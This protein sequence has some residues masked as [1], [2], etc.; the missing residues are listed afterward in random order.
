MRYK[1]QSHEKR[2]L[3]NNTKNKIGDS[4][5]LSDVHSFTCRR[6][7]TRDV[8]VTNETTSLISNRGAFVFARLNVSRI[9]CVYYV[10]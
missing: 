5:L 2:S 7:R 9:L 1:V 6:I 4:H 10:Y 3:A 8:I